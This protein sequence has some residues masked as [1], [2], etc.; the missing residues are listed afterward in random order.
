MENIVKKKNEKLK[1]AI[2]YHDYV[3]SIIPDNITSLNNKGKLLCEN[4]RKEDGIKLFD[5]VIKLNPQDLEANLNKGYALLELKKYDEAIEY[6]EKSIL[7]NQK[8]SPTYSSSL[9]SQSYNFKATA[10]AKKKDLKR[11]IICFNIAISI[12]PANIRAINNR[13]SAQNELGMFDE[14]AK[15]FNQIESLKNNHKEIYQKSLNIQGSTLGSLKR[16]DEAIDCFN[17][18]IA[19]KQ[20]TV[21]NINA[22]TLK[23]DTLFKIEKYDEALLIFNE[24]NEKDQNNK[25]LYHRRG[26]I[27]LLKK[28][29]ELALKLYRKSISIDPKYFEGIYGCASSLQYLK[30]FK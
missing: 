25:S 4:G 8:S 27:Y 26:F 5:Q 12:D 30:R 16:Y 11:A 10:L 7:Y 2:S 9:L 23:A 22:L 20:N 29:F 13:S 18:S 21:D 19:F 17:K 28:E 1:K 6:F 3:L 14:S 15:G 24:L